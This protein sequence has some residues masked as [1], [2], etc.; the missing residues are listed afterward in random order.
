MIHCEKIVSITTR[1]MQLESVQVFGKTR[2][3]L[4]KQATMDMIFS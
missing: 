1:P 4:D 3:Q 2:I